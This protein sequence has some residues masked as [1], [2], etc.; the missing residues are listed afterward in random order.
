M[1]KNA[2]MSPCNLSLLQAA[3]CWT[4]YTLQKTAVMS[5]LPIH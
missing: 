1:Q 4:V 2:V 3:N 5:L